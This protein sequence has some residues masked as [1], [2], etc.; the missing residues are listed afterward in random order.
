M[1]LS[2][3]EYLSFIR[4]E[5]APLYFKVK[6]MN[7]KAENFDKL[8]RSYVAPFNEFRSTWDHMFKA[9]VSPDVEGLMSNLSEAKVHLYRAGYDVYEIFA[10]DLSMRV[11]DSMDKYSS[12]V[13]SRIFP[14]YFNEI[15]PKIISIHEDLT[16]VRANKNVDTNGNS[17]SFD[18]YEKNIN[19]LI[20]IYKRIQGYIPIFE[21]EEKR[22]V[23]SRIKEQ[24][25]G[26]LITLG[27]GI[28]LG[29]ILFK[30][31]LI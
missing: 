13:I 9:A 8:S 3:E 22:D 12:S 6:E 25:L 5:L 18:I 7:I 28:I 4:K 11:E 29:F 16:K 14:A 10:S 26:I 21:K 19:D 30:L 1:S 17:V 31:G 2:P 24:S 23:W 27:T 15:Q 20:E